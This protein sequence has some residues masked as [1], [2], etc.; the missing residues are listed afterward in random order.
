MENFQIKK[1]LIVETFISARCG[2][3]LINTEMNLMSDKLH[4]PRIQ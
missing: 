4:A 3:S 1:G 2:G